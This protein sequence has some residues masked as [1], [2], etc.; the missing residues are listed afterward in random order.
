MER[1][2]EMLKKVKKGLPKEDGKVMFLI[3]T[4]LAKIT[5]K[6]EEVWNIFNDILC[7][8]ALPR[9]LPFCDIHNYIRFNLNTAICIR[10]KQLGFKRSLIYWTWNDILF[11]IWIYCRIMII[12]LLAINEVVFTILWR[13]RYMIIVCH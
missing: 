6:R 12:S 5:W 3:F 13:P 10:G 1:E 11:E 4:M 7:F 2:R 9:C 8:V